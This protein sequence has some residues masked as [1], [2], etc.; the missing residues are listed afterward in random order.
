MRISL[1]KPKI[2]NLKAFQKVFGDKKVNEQL[3]GYPYPLTLQKAKNKLQEIINL[4]KKGDYY[5]FAIIF[6]K[7][8]VGT[9]VLENPSKNKKT[10]TLGYALGSKYWNKGI[11]TEAAKKMIKFGFN[12]L[13]LKKIKSDHDS[14][15]PASG[16]V[17]E[18]A[19]F[20]KVKTIKGKKNK[21]INVIFYEI[22]K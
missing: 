17:L 7:K 9:V 22:T 21:N 10:F 12:K 6:N 16:R 2:S 4:N 1:R 3:V 11:T 18:K 13:K 14:D 15:N 5:E 8:F 19:G 20:K